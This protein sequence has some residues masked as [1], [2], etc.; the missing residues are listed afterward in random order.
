MTFP[1]DSS[2]DYITM[3]SFQ[4]LSLSFLTVCLWERSSAVQPSSKM[5]AVSYFITGNDDAFA[6]DMEEDSGNLILTA[7]IDS[8][9][10]VTLNVVTSHYFIKGAFA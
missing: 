1:Q 3:E 9:E 8:V 10:Y 2:T 7:R 4:F 6:M 5:S